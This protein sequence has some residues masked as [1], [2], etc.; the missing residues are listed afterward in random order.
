MFIL[1]SLLI[2]KLR[3]YVNAFL[4]PSLS[5]WGLCV[6]PSFLL[7]SSLCS[8]FLS[9]FLSL[10]LPSLLSLVAHEPEGFGG[11]DNQPC[12]M[13]HSP[14]ILQGGQLQKNSTSTPEVCKHTYTV[15]QAPSFPFFLTLPKHHNL[16]IHPL[17]LFCTHTHTQSCKKF[18]L[19]SAFNV[20][21]LS[22][23]FP[24]FFV[25][26]LFSHLLCLFIRA[27]FLFSSLYHDLP[28]QPRRSLRA[29]P[30]LNHYQ[31]AQ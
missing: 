11:L 21:A 25:F 28:S 17:L 24:P 13:V 2:T 5:F 7:I 30:R 19:S 15:S 23:L 29:P 27:L 20:L 9:L 6:H 10:F 31:T 8:T 18:Q 14:L 22:P 16:S 1:N 3:G 12:L 4:S 26:P